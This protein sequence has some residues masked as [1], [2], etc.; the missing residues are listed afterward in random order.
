MFYSECY[1]QEECDKKGLE[2]GS[3][4]QSGNLFTKEGLDA[5]FNDLDQ[6]FENSDDTSS[7]EAVSHYVYLLVNCNLNNGLV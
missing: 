2:P 5:S 4:L 1:V 6:I 3:K 7:D